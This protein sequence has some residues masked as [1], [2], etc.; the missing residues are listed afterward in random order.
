MDDRVQRIEER[1]ADVIRQVEDL[2][3]LAARQDREIERLSTR[4][5]MLL[6]RE[7][8]RETEGGGAH[9]YGDETPP[10]Y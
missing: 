9:L 4:V 2:S 6:E 1:L 7:A 10:H 3:D 8:Q 5:A